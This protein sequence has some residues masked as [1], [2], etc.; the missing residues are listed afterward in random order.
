MGGAQLALFSRLSASQTSHSASL[1]L[2]CS[3]SHFFVSL[4]S[5]PEGGSLLSSA[6]TETYFAPSDVF[7]TVWFDLSRSEQIAEY[8]RYK[9]KK[10]WKKNLFYGVVVNLGTGFAYVFPQILS[11]PSENFIGSHLT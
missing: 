8:G 7:V 10:N 1:L 11:L 4:P 6:N 3:R 5:I 2:P 9:N